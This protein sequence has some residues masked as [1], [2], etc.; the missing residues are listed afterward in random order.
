M[1]K[2]LVG[3][4]RLAEEDQENLMDQLK[5]LLSSN[6]AYF[7]SYTPQLKSIFAQNATKMYLFKF[8]TTQMVPNREIAYT[9]PNVNIK[10]V[11]PILFDSQIEQG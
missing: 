1:L 9:K 10:I 2:T 8:T 11:R 4:C 7:W 6:C 3:E 5:Q